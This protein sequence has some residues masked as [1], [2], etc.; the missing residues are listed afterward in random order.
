YYDALRLD[1]RLDPYDG[2]WWQ[3][4]LRGVHGSKAERRIASGRPI[5]T[6]PVSSPACRC[7]ERARSFEAGEGVGVHACSGWPGDVFLLAVEF[8]DRRALFPIGFKRIT[9]GSVVGAVRPVSATVEQLIGKGPAEIRIQGYVRDEVRTPNCTSDGRCWS[10]FDHTILGAEWV[11]T[12]PPAPRIQ[13]ALV[14]RMYGRELSKETIEC[15]VQSS[16]DACGVETSNPDSVRREFDFRPDERAVIVGD[17]RYPTDGEPQIFPG[18]GRPP[19]LEPIGTRLSCG[20]GPWDWAGLAD[21]HPTSTLHDEFRRTGTLPIAKCFDPLEAGTT[22]YLAIHAT[23]EGIDPAAS[24]VAERS[25]HLLEELTDEEVDELQ[26]CLDTVIGYRDEWRPDPDRDPT[27]PFS[28]LH[29][30]CSS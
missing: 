15:F 2:R 14:D 22:I 20:L 24:G 11:L 6:A 17:E 13:V 25:L 21:N 1:D 28:V 18:D 5:C 19:L 26:A 16:A 7:A 12:R 8:G 23:E 4:V 27:P 29:P 3:D 9:G 10:N 30:E